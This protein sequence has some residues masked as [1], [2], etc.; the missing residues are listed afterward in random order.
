MFLM[1]I[2]YPIV[3]VKSIEQNPQDAETTTE[4]LL[5]ITVGLKKPYVFNVSLSSSKMMRIEQMTNSSAEIED[6]LGLLE[7]REQDLV[8]IKTATNSSGSI[9]IALV[10]TEEEESSLTIYGWMLFWFVPYGVNLHLHLTPKD[11][12]NKDTALQSTRTLVR[13]ACALI[14][15]ALAYAFQPGALV[16]AC[17]WAVLECFIDLT[18]MDYEVIYGNSKGEYGELDIWFD[19]SVYTPLL[20]AGNGLIITTWNYVWLLTYTGIWVLEDR[21]LPPPE[22][23]SYGR[24]GGAG[25]ALMV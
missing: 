25:K 1:V 20:M 22:M 8:A 2:G 18:I 7:L 4:T 24:A 17:V 19:L 16:A 10:R 5:T 21:S 12:I 13:V 6:V 11:A 9:K 14:I 15:A 23:P 3:Q